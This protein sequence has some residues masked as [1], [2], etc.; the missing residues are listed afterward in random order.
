M[1]FKLHLKSSLV[2]SLKDRMSSSSL[3]MLEQRLDSHLVGML[4]KGST[5]EQVWSPK[6]TR[7]GC[8]LCSLR[9]A[10]CILPA[11]CGS[12]GIRATSRSGVRGQQDLAYPQHEEAV[13]TFGSDVVKQ[14]PEHLIL[15][16]FT[17]VVFTN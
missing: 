12:A 14:I 17:D 16:P 7:N 10:A 2:K 1:T 15:L 6:M 4:Q 3:E 13:A 11:T 9:R 8:E 5:C